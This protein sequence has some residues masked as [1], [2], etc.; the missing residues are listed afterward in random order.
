VVV[1]DEAGRFAIPVLSGHLGGANALAG[2]LADRARRDAG[3]DHRLG[4]PR[5]R[6]PST[7][8][9]ANS[10]GPSRRP[11][12]TRPRSAA[13][14]NDEPVALVQE[15][16]ST[17]WWTR[18]ANGRS[19]PL[20]ANVHA[21]PAS[22]TSIPTLSPPCSGSADAPCPPTYAARLAG[23]RVVYRPGMK[24]RSRPAERSSLASLGVGCDRGTPAATIA[25]AIDEALAACGGTRR[26]RPRGRQHRPQ[27][28]RAGLLKVASDR[29]AGRIRFYPAAELAAST[30]PIPRKPCAATPARRRSPKRRPC[31]PPAPT[32]TPA[33]R[34]TQAAR[35]RRPQRHRLH[36]QDPHDA[37]ERTR[38]N[39]Q[40][41]ARRPRPGSLEHLTGRARAAIAEADTV[42][43]YA[44]Y[45][46]LV[47]DLLEGKEVIRKSMTEELDRAIE[48]L[49]RARQGKK[50]ALV[51]SG[52]AG[53]YGMAGPT[54]EVL[55]QSG[56][57][58]E[59]ESRSRS[60][61]APRRST[62]APRW[63]AR[64]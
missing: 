48:A 9:A 39:R 26:R 6:W 2:H 13:V 16:G 8:S 41:H 7:C 37:N 61:P 25:Q 57:T 58:P 27:G 3:A 30:C 14:V 5:R 42:I 59:S 51:S 38:K 49:E 23:K 53:V 40:D 36:R 60:S 20:P 31:S 62:P 47:A 15:A 18:H 22:K 63:S 11:C 35:P 21:S 32:A 28:R 34:K 17:D 44:T 29:T 45:I 64:R 10:A 52:D 19:G 24:T 46:R 12:R 54:F 43:G 1:I 55:F 50:V 56:W 4:R 33:H